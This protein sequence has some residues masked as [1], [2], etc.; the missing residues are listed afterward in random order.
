M[1]FTL[2]YPM[3]E[4]LT[5]YFNLTEPMFLMGDVDD[6]LRIPDGTNISLDVNA[7][8]V[9]LPLAVLVSR[10]NPRIKSQRGR[11][12]AF[13]L[14]SSLQHAKADKWENTI[15]KEQNGFRNLSLEKVHEY[16]FSVWNKK[17]EKIPKTAPFLYKIIIDSSATKTIAE[18]LQSI[19]ISKEKVY[20]ELENIGL[21]IKKK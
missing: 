16:Y 9:S 4:R 2:V 14:Y 3:L 10:L 5:I 17:T 1:P 11:F 12:L 6:S 18:W 7:G 20:P 15:E 13:N 19:G 21:K 8:L